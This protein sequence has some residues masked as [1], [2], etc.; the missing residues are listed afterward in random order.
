MTSNYKIEFGIRH[1]TQEGSIGKYEVIYIYLRF[2]K[3][4]LIIINPRKKVV[5]L[6]FSAKAFD[7]NNF[8]L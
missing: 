7:Q 5:L 4:V 8:L 2:N 3:K 1:K 6:F